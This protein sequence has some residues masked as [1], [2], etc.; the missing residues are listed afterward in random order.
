MNATAAIQAS[1]Q[2]AKGSHKQPPPPQGSVYHIKDLGRTKLAS[3][4]T[5]TSMV[6][7]STDALSCMGLDAMW[8]ACCVQRLRIATITSDRLRRTRA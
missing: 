1:V 5:G 7:F 3:T 2:F 6:A 8:A 4:C